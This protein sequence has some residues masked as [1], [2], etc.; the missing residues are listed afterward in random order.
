M[1]AGKTHMV[2]MGQLFATS[3]KASCNGG[4]CRSILAMVSRE[5]A[6]TILEAWMSRAVAGPGWLWDA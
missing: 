1:R 5:R 2:K 6:S 4:C 3:L